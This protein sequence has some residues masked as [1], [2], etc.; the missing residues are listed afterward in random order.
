MRRLLPLLLA[1]GPLVRAAEVTVNAPVFGGSNY[2]LTFSVR[3][4]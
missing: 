2:T 4:S 3:G 1:T